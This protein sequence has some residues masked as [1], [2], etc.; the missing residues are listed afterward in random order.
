[1]KWQCQYSRLTKALRP[2]RRRSPAGG[3]H[4]LAQAQAAPGE[5]RRQP[6][7]RG[8]RLERRG[9]AAAVLAAARIE[10]ARQ[11]VERRTS[12]AALARRRL[13][14]VEAERDRLGR[15]RGD[16]H[17]RHRPRGPVGREQGRRQRG[18]AQFSR[19]NGLRRGDMR[20]PRRLPT[21]AIIE[22]A[23]HAELRHFM[24][25]HAACP[26]PRRDCAVTRVARTV[27]GLLV[28]IQIGEGRRGMQAV[29]H[30]DR[31]AHHQVQPTAA[32]AQFGVQLARALEHELVVLARG[33]RL[34]PQRRLDDRHA[35]HR[36]AAR[37]RDERAVVG[38]TEVTLEPDQPVAHR[39]HSQAHAAPAHG[40]SARR[41]RPGRR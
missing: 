31:V 18:K 25:A 34:S 11:R 6:R 35:Q 8:G 27:A 14:R 29:E 21:I 37:R 39:A 40:R 7:A 32:L 12:S 28:R 9:D 17:A 26:A 2:A 38:E 41:P 10:K 20:L 5:I 19:Q 30:L 16:D 15:T 4:Q 33:V 24:P 13:K 3:L 1:M 22:P 23:H 36:P